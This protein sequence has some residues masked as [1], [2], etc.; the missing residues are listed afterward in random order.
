MNMHDISV[1][2][3]A[4]RPSVA[5][6]AA[7]VGEVY[8]F[9]CHPYFQWAWS[10]K[11][12]RDDFRRSQVPFIYIVEY[13]SQALAA[14]LAHIPSVRQRLDTVFDNVLEEH[15]GGKFELTHRA[16]FAEYLKMLGATEGEINSPCPQHVEA[17]TEALL[18]YCLVHPAEQGAALMGIIEYVYVGISRTIVELIQKRDWGDVSA[19]RHYAAHEK[20]DVEHAERLFALAVEG[21]KVAERRDAI[22]SAMLVSAQYFWTVYDDMLL[23][24][25]GTASAAA[26]RTRAARR[27]AEAA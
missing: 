6:G 19:Q 2:S 1:A 16:T 23:S 10:P 25:T 4:A 11:C 22:A 5:G 8:D 9:T 27:V 12:S 3:V 13:F 14:V 17:F 21:W 15:G 7:L 24:A 18:N 26:T 20:I